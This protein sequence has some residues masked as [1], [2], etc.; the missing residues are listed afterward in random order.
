MMDFLKENGA[1][2]NLDKLQAG[3]EERL[4]SELGSD[5]D[6]VTTASREK[7]IKNGTIILAV[8]FCV[9]LVCL[10]FMIKKTTPQTA[11]AK[12]GSEDIKVEDAIAKITGT[13]AEFF[14]GVD[15][16]MSKFRDFSGTLQVKVN[17][18]QKNPFEH[19]RYSTLAMPLDRQELFPA[20][21]RNAN[22][23]RQSDGMQLLGIMKSPKGYCC[24]IND[25]TLYKGDTV[26]GWKIVAIT[27]DSVELS[28]RSV[29]KTLRISGE[30]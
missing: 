16:V 8:I 29:Q 23:D 21:K 11:A 3:D 15:N 30:D 9:S 14:K 13:K 27:E 26:D 22:T 6:Y 19:E 20:A 2:K 1:A 24:M 17:E 4:N 25:K 7:N 5:S 12:T 18:L 10:W 28:S